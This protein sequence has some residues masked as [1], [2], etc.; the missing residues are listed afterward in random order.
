MGP[1][2]KNGRCRMHGGKAG[3]KPIHGRYTNAALD[4]RRRVRELLRT[5]RELIGK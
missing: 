2:M 1:A 5:L 4:Q 3:R